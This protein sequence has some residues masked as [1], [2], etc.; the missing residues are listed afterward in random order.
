M[1]FAPQSEFSGGSRKVCRVRASL[2]ITPSLSFDLTLALKAIDKLYIKDSVLRL[3]Y[4][5]R[6]G[7]LELSRSQLLVTGITAGPSL[8][9]PRARG[10]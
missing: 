8:D 3:H 1:H 7:P 10:R 5:P 9:I 4:V 2:L 6:R